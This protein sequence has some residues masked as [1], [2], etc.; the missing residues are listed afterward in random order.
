MIVH[1]VEQARTDRFGS[2]FGQIRP[3]VVEN[4]KEKFPVADSEF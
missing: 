2:A 4:P 1:C 3:Y